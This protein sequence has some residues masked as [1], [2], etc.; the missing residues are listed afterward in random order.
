MVKNGVIIDVKGILNSK[1]F[2]S[3]GIDVWQ[4]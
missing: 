2:K 3:V 4:L 1:E